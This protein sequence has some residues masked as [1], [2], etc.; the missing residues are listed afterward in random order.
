M[1]IRGNPKEIALGLALGLFVS[2]SPFMGLHTAIA[3]CIA[4]VLKWNKIS[5]AIGVW[6]SNPF[7]APIIYGI[8]W[9]VGSN[10]TGMKLADNLPETFSIKAS[11]ALILKTPTILW[12]LTI[13]GIVVGIPLAI[14]AYHVTFGLVKRY[15]DEVRDKLKA[16][17]AR[18]KRRKKKRKKKRPR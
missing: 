8:T 4:A 7:T 11:L 14:L 13:G 6:L 10:I 16:R 1:K 9:F 15:Q 18:R 12:T 17:K 5:A 2:M 3:V